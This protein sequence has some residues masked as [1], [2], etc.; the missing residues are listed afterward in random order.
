MENIQAYKDWSPSQFDRKGLNLP[1]HQEWFVAPIVHYP[2]LNSDP[3]SISNWKSIQNILDLE[4]IEYEIHYF[5]HWVSDFEIILVHPS[6]KKVLDDILNHLSDCPIL[7]ENHYSETEY[8]M[9]YDD[10]MN[11]NGPHGLVDSLCEYIPMSDLLV[12]LLK[13]EPEIV[14]R[15]G[16]WTYEYYDAS[17]HFY[18]EDIE[19]IT[20]D[21]IVRAIKNKD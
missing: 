15:I 9:A 3:L 20:R 2:K 11:F 14:D 17:F 4:D 16:Q 10:F 5:K 21:D 7:D 1:D 8:D 13:N 12:S 6:G 19:S 18:W